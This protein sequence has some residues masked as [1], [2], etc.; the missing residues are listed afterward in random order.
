MDPRITEL[1]LKVLSDMRHVVGQM[2]NLGQALQSVLNILFQHLST[3]RASISLKNPETGRLTVKAAGGL[4]AEERK[5]GLYR[6]NEAAARRILGSVQAF[7]LPERSDE[8]LLAD[9]A[10]LRH[11]EK[12]RLS[13]IGAPI[14]L[15]REEPFGIFVV[16]RLYGESTSLKNDLHFLTVLADW[17]AQ[18]VSVNYRA[19]ERESRF[20]RT[21][22]ALKR[23]FAEKFRHFFSEGR[24][25][26]LAEAQELVRKVAP[27]RTSVLL[28][29]ETGTGKTLVARI[30]HELGGKGGGPFVTMNC[31]AFGEAFAESELFGHEKGAFAGAL[32]ANP[33]RVEQ[34]DGG[35][36][37]LN[38][39]S[40]L[41]LPAQAKLLRLLQDREFERL[42]ATRIR[43]VDVRVIAGASRDLEE[44][45]AKGLFRQDLYYR[46]NV[47]PISLAPLREQREEI[48][49]LL[50][51]FATKLAREYGRGLRFT[52]RAVDA[53]NNYSWPGNVREMENLME[54]LA[55]TFGA[56]LVDVADLAPYI[57]GRIGELEKNHPN[58]VSSLKEMERRGVLA[59]LE[60]NNWIQSRAAKELGITLRQMG[61]RVK[62]FGL[63]HLVKQRRSGE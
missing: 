32:E 44:A 34:A 36:I 54:R 59:A 52:P 16:D 21:N 62:K 57:S 8:P 6:L 24:S 28:L 41:P 60:R 26:S 5:G 14:A 47:F 3:K 61:Y 40:Q 10:V 46:L 4:Q 9:E 11:I 33:G 13:F 19:R 39:I 31:A 43:K 25:D 53:L 51:F 2:L 42:G 35:S 12:R 58:E 49:P 55:L 38:E 7:V 27:T 15:H 18:L 56:D 30:I 1:E 63:E 50:N 29:G 22:V 45:V 20:I 37:F 17:V 48:A 23:D